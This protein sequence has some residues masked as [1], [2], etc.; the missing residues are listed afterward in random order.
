MTVRSA[1]AP[2]RITV[3]VTS[4]SPA[5][6]HRRRGRSARAR[7]GPPARR[8]C[9]PPIRPDIDPRRCRCSLCGMRAS[10]NVQLLLPSV[11]SAVVVTWMMAP[12][13]AP[14]TC[15]TSSASTPRP[16]PTSLKSAPQGRSVTS[17][18]RPPPEV[19]GLGPSRVFSDE[20]PLRE[21]W[22]ARAHELEIGSLA[23]GH[24]IGARVEDDAEGVVLAVERA[25]E[26]QL[27][28]PC[29]RNDDPFGHLRRQHR[30]AAGWCPTATPDECALAGIP[31][32]NTAG[33]GTAR[34]SS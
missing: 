16:L 28:D 18:V 10:R 24:P 21:G 22:P 1:P 12:A 14:E 11:S 9:R 3:P 33:P 34:R 5:R 17:R 13:C 26:A 23:Q 31:W 29:G 32:K 6:R 19:Q 2:R 25:P 30:R 7:T 20:S 8:S 15:S 4:R 27:F